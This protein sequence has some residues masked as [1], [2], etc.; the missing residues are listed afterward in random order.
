MSNF[1][2]SNNRQLCE[3]VRNN[4]HCERGK[5]KIL[6]GDINKYILMISNELLYKDIERRELLGIDRYGIEN[7]INNDLIEE[8]EDDIIVK[9][10]YNNIEKLFMELYGENYEGTKKR[11]KILMN[12]ENEYLMMNENYPLIKGR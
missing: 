6:K 8:K 7:I 1:L 4:E 10:M 9:D 3:N 5:F 12:E 2:I 11:R